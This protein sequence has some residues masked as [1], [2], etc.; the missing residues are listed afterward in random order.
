MTQTTETA[1]RKRWDEILD[2]IPRDVTTHGAE[3]GVWRACLS[4]RLLKAREQLHLLLVDPWLAQGPDSSYVKS[5]DTKA[6]RMQADFDRSFRITH[7][8]LDRF[9]ARARIVRKFSVDAEKAVEVRSLD[10]VFIDGDHS[11]EAVYTD[12]RAWL[13]KVKPGGWIGGHDYANDEYKH[14]GVKQAVDEAF[15]LGSGDFV[16][17]VQKKSR[18]DEIAD[19]IELGEDHTWFVRVTD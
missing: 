1:R 16:D 18:Q 4:K 3:I 10:F 11:Y 9:G 12:I 6:G 15:G 19:A 2:R 5:G 17:G 13:P 7:E 14:W 8:M